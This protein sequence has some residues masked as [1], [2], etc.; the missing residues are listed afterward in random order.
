MSSSAPAVSSHPAAVAYRDWEG[1]TPC[2]T[3]HT[4]VALFV[5][6]GLSFF[7]DASMAV[8]NIP[9]FTV[10]HLEVWRLVLSPLFSNSLLNLIF[11][12]MMF[13]PLGTKSERAL[14]TVGFGAL[15]FTLAVSANALFCGVC[16]LCAL[17]G[18]YEAVFYR[19]SGFWPLM[20]SLLVVESMHAP[21][22]ERRLF[23]LPFA[24]PN[25]YFPLALYALV[26][27]VSGPKL[28]AAV[29]C[30]VRWRWRTS[31]R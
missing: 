18:V 16:Y 23:M 24:I 13:S 22:V 1:R 28:D 8:S 21:D 17:T 29:G 20:F 25:K 30:A 9:F 2:L 12:C 7:I 27:L 26:S 4:L 6:Y 19:A 5:C 15:L 3:R 14:G 10:Q 11:V 31:R